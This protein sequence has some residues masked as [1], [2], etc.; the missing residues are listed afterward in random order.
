MTSEQ[1]W[2]QRWISLSQIDREVLGPY[3]L[4][5]EREFRAGYEAASAV[6]GL[7]YAKWIH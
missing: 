1:A 7:E 3:R 4:I 5:M 2:A 6:R